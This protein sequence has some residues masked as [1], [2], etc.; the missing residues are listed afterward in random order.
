MYLMR[1]SRLLSV[2]GAFVSFVSLLIVSHSTAAWAYSSASR[3]QQASPR[4]GND[5]GTLIHDF[6]SVSTLTTA[7]VQHVF[8]FRNNTSGSEVV[9]DIQPSC[10]CTSATVLDGTPDGASL[11]IELPAGG[12]IRIEVC[13]D[14]QYLQPGPINKFVYV[15]LDGQSLPITTF[16]MTGTLLPP[17]AITP[18]TIDFGAVVAGNA[19]QH[20]VTVHIDPSLLLYGNR[21]KL[22][23]TGRDLII[24]QCFSN[25]AGADVAARPMQ[26]HSF[27][28][29]TV[30]ETYSVALS[31]HA[32][33]GPLHDTLAW[34]VSPSPSLPEPLTQGKS[35]SS[36]PS[37]TVTIPVRGTVVSKIASL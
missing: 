25:N 19:H 6:G 17:V 8:V 22:V 13:T 10:G 21:A 23:A 20:R 16:E 30:T 7:S 4:I 1:F 27:I 31:S 35:G 36:A 26:S 5:L 33:P 28:G 14:L 37:V 15:L 9:A 12:V 11:P 2:T 18:S 24:N 29:I 32:R 3:S 34:V